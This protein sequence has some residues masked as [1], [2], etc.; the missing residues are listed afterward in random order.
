MAELGIAASVLQITT[1]GF[2]LAHELFQY[3]ESN[4]SSG[5]RV[6]DIGNDVKITSGIVE[7]LQ[8][9]FENNEA[10]ISEN[11]KKT[12]RL[13][14]DEC[15]GTF[16]RINVALD[17]CKGRRGRWIFP[18]REDTFI[19][20]RTNLNRLKSSLEL[21]MQIVILAHVSSRSPQQQPQSE[22]EVTYGEIYF[23]RTKVE[24][25]IQ[26]SKE[27]ERKHSDALKLS[28]I[29]RARES[30]ESPIDDADKHTPKGKEI[31]SSS[32]ISGIASAS[33]STPPTLL[34]PQN[35]YSSG[36]DYSPMDSKVKSL[37][38]LD[39]TLSYINNLIT[40][41]MRA[42][43]QILSEAKNVED[44]NYEL[45]AS[46]RRCR[47]NLDTLFSVSWDTNIM[48]PAPDPNFRRRRSAQTEM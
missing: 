13:A 9:V 46:Y 14:L 20:L 1:V 11:A 17:K 34:Q 43:V 41:I 36:I 10:I 6:R 7:E 25:L 22:P 32:A 12:V 4:R 28:S 8:I 5:E 31:S 33:I 3:A 38:T 23:Q 48:R 26:T 16:A 21:L 18:F 39:N 44:I 37:E 19:L 42:Q 35:P 24:D 40:K 47:Q 2:K 45:Q 29:V 30:I 27:A 15:Q